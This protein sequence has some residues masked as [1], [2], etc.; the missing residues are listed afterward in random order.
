MR[1]KVTARDVAAAAGTSVAA[2]SRAFSAKGAIAPALRDRILRIAA[3]LGYQPPVARALSRLTTGTITLVAG[4]LDNPFY[5]MAANALSQAIVAR[6][7]R[8]VLHPVT[9]GHEVDAVMEQILTF[10]SDAVIVTSALMSSHIARAC[11]ERHLPVVLFNRVQPDAR[12]TAVTCDNHG[13]GRMVAQRF[14]ET[15]RQRIALIGGKKNTST[16]LERTRGFQDRLKEGGLELTA[17]LAGNYDYTASLQAAR[18]LLTARPA[19]D[20]IFCVNDVMALAAIDAARELGLSV[21]DDVAIIGFDDVAMAGWAAYRL[22]TVRQ[23][24]ARMADQALD[25]VE[26]QLADPAAEGTIRVLPVDLVLRD[27][28]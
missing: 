18:T 10:P 28:G 15:G 14:L 23:P 8:M 25:L 24:I 3:D 21:P 5:P 4:D 16:H 17:S 9:P 26:A 19:P 22:T 20:A 11:R 2:V 6:G 27:S 1:R 7:R 12:M 13:G